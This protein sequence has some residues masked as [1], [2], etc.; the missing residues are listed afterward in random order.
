MKNQTEIDLARAVLR[1]A[2]F[3]SNTFEAPTCR[4]CLAFARWNRKDSKYRPLIHHDG[5][6]VLKA[7]EIIKESVNA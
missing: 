7:E 1:T 6:I 4:H 3:D 2:W 5:C